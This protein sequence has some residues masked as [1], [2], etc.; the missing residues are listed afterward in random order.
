MLRALTRTLPL[1]R[2]NTVFQEK[3][4]SLIRMGVDIVFAIVTAR[5]TIIGAV[6]AEALCN[7]AC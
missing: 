5:E 7:C 4:V 6:G 3:T 1:N 2:A